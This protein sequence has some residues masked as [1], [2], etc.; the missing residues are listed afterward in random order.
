ML[1]WVGAHQRAVLWV[2]AAIFFGAL[3]IYYLPPGQAWARV[4]EYLEGPGFPHFVIR[5]RQSWFLFDLGHI[6]PQALNG[7]SLNALAL[8]DFAVGPNL[9]LLFEPFTAYAISQFLFRTLGAIGMYLLCRDYLLRTV[10]PEWRLLI[11]V[12]TAL[13][14]AL[15]NHFPARLGLTLY[16]PVFLWALANVVDG[17]R[18]SVSYVAIFAYP[19]VWMFALGAY[20][21]PPLLFALAGL[22]FALRHASWR[23]V[24][25]LAVAFSVFVVLVEI[26]DVI[27]LLG[28]GDS[29]R[30]QLVPEGVPTFEFGESLRRFVEHLVRDPNG[31]HLQGK[32]PFG[33]VLVV[34]AAAVALWRRVRN[35]GP[36]DDQTRDLTGWLGAG[37]LAVFLIS[38]Y[39]AVTSANELWVMHWIGISM[40]ID[41]I[42]FASSVL[43]YCLIAVGA[44][45]LVQGGSL[46]RLAGIGMLALV[47]A[48][49]GQQQMFGIKE[50]IADALNAP[51]QVSLRDL[52]VR[53]STGQDLGR[54]LPPNYLQLATFF[55]MDAFPQIDAALAPLG[56]PSGYR[57]ISFA[58]S[59]SIALFHGYYALDGAYHTAPLATAQAF[60]ALFPQQ[61]RLP[62]KNFQPLV[63]PQEVLRDGI[64]PAFDTCRFRSLGGRVVFSGAR[65]LNADELGLQLVLAAGGLTP[66]GRR[67]D[68]LYARLGPID[69]IYV[70][71]IPDAGPCWTGA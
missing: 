31:H 52:L 37:L 17:R 22:L 49:A 47:L 58:L 21:I 38:A 48:Y 16:L 60:Q 29:S 42:D 61:D 46:S 30:S 8:S 19:L 68:D 20:F 41:R 26:R 65:L 33:F 13:A 2:A 53:R 69:T 50:R 11:A 5:A 70:Y 64:A 15:I 28:E 34:G 39:W 44:A 43:W 36:P 1:A 7:I 27:L 3:S 71:R 25:I 45:I 57:V 59:S 67:P 24:A 12:A 18:L 40:R 51:A 56:D 55:R 35:A 6:V 54:V 62:T 10:T 63:R 32:W 14:F 23:R 4:H 66:I 9:Y